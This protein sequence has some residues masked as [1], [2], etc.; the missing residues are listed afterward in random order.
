MPQQPTTLPPFAARHIGPSESDVEAMLAVV[1]QASLDALV[2]QA[3]P[4]QIRADRALRVQPAEN[5]SAVI[6]E[7]RA[8]AARNTVAR[9]MIGLGYYGTVTPPVVLRNVLENPAW[10]TA[11]TPYQPEISQGRL[12]ALLNFQTVVSD[13]TGLPIAGSSLL[14]EGTAAAEAMT[15]MRRSV[16]GAADAVLLVDAQVLPQTI[17]VLQ[18]R[19]RPL[20]LP[21]VVA[22]L[23]GVTDVAGL[24]AAAD[25]PVFGVLVQYPAA[26]GE[27]RDWS[28]LTAAAHDA[29][30][31]V[32]VAADLLALTLLRAPG[33]WGA[34]IAVGSAQ[35]F[36]VP[37][38]FGGPH[39]G[40]MAVRPGL[41]RAMPGRLV[42]VSVDSHGKPAYRLALQTREQHIR[43]EKATSNICTAQVLL[44]VMASMYAVW[45][46]PEGLAEIARRVHRQARALAAGLAAGGVEVVTSTPFDAITVRVPG[47]AERIQQECRLRG[48]NVWLVDGDTLSMSCDETTSLADI[49]SVWAAF[50]VVD[51]D[52]GA[53]SDEPAWSAAL[54]RD[55][56]YL[57]HPVFHE[58]RSETAMLR[59][60]RR[61]ADR[62]FALDRGMIPLGSCTMKLNATTEMEAITWPEF[63]HLH[64][65]APVTQT[66]GIRALIA[67]LSTWLAEI[68]GYDQ[69]SLQPNAGSQGELAGLLA[70]HAYHEA[71]GEGHRR[72]CLIPA[73]AHGTNAASAVMA[74]LQ[75]VVVKTAADGSVDLADLRAKIEQHAA[76]LAAIMVTYP[77]THGVYEDTITELCEVVHA[78]GGQVYVDGANLNALVGLAQPGKFGADVSHLNLHKTFCIPHGGGGP[79]VGPVAVREH[80]APYLPNHPLAPEAG[81]ATGVGP[82]SAAPYGSAGILPISWAYVRLMGGAGLARATQVAVLNANYVAA[83]LRQ[84]YPVLYSG[85]GGLVAHECILD[86][87][88]ITRET[89]VT[90][91]DV[92]KRL[93]DYGFHAPT[94][95]FPVAGTL[96]VEPT[97]SEDKRELDRFCEAMIAIRDE[98]EAVHKGDVATAE[99]VL[100]GAPHTA[101]EIAGEWERAYD[102]QLAAFPAGVDPTAKYWP[103]VGR[104]DGAYGDR[105]L[106]CA[107]PPPEAFEG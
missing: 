26:D 4:G 36:G 7:L 68:T 76:Q 51:G 70:I 90:V 14:D 82:V 19:A 29:G 35:R 28:A 65:F 67:D 50:G 49:E 1:G 25:A 105:N 5:E 75:V 69:V 79:G 93:I 84:H 45:H 32:T 58:H 16:K 87:R 61:L 71:R 106:V 39:A 22:D 85:E 31:L 78:A 102:R 43:R 9:S 21:I 91:D 72:I 2:E 94:M 17:A 86:L 33:E 81:P 24:R 44:A 88:A 8:L 74:G 59:Y 89:G 48:I 11:Y 101:Y 27:V 18:T 23:T 80:L 97:E 47:E 34:D 100:R 95:S 98:I 10:Y 38:G 54:Q 107:C 46:G 3:V 104:I 52:P 53:V 63:A 40:F 99:S 15:L 73:S 77:S 55:A 30:A 66:E 13:L 20:G 83:R 103:P 42:G 37:M 92:A 64:P 6:D 60:L 57:T 12:E 41:E 96:M 56:A 62:D